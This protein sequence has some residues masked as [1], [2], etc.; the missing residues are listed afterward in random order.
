M[1]PSGRHLIAEFIYC[2]K[3][4]LNDGER[5]EAALKEAIKECGFGLRKILTY[6]FQP[7]GV[8]SIAIISESHVAIHT[9][10]EAQH[11]SVDVFTCAPIPEKTRRLLNCLK[12]TFQP[13]KVSTTEVLRGNPLEIASTSWITNFSSNGFAVRYHVKR[14]LVDTQSRYQHI[15]IIENDDFGRMLFLDKDLQI[16]EADA[17]L[18]NSSL[19]PPH[20]GRFLK[21]KE[22]AILGGGDGG[23]LHEVLKYNPRKVTLVELDE[24]VIHYSKRYLNSICNNAFDDPRVDIVIEEAGSFLDRA[25]TF[26]LFIYDLTLHPEAFVDLDRETY[27]STLLSKLRKRLKDGGLLTIQCGSEFDKETQDLVN[28]IL[29]SHFREVEYNS[30]F[31]P[32]FCEK[33]VFG[34]AKA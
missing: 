32:S 10:P 21:G 6:R 7:A 34:V 15:E 26:D 31:I 28:R 11:A 9:Y 27:L 24:E 22:I 13:K 3:E 12:A 14:K 23:V 4:I 16:A 1:K 8:T 19:L 5:I 18:Y 20:I 2:G 33:W 25:K 29:T 30:V 17:H